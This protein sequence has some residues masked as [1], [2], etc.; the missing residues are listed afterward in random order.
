M[1]ETS[2]TT[3]R[4]AERLLAGESRGVGPAIARGALA[5]IEPAYA[6][7]MT[8]RNAAYDRGWL[9]SHRLPR[10]TISIG[11]ITTGGTG[12]T[13]VVQWLSDQLRR[14]GRRPAILLRGY[15]ASAGRSDEQ[16][17]LE[18]L[19]NQDAPPIPVIANPDRVAGAQQAL[20][21]IPDIDCFLLD[22]AFQHRRVRRDLDIVLINAASPF[23]FGH[24][25]PRGL[26][27]ER[28]AGLKRADVLILT[29]CDRVSVEDLN[30]I[31]QRIRR[32]NPRAPIL[33]ARHQIAGFVDAD[34]RPMDLS[35]CKAFVFTGIGDPDSVVAQVRPMVEVVAHRAFPDHH[36]YTPADLQ[37]IQQ[38]PADVYV[39]TEKDFVKVRPLSPSFPLARIQLEIA[40]APGHAEQL[41]ERVLQAVS[42]ELPGG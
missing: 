18:G 3:T 8:I 19:L 38:T 4:R 20:Q 40:F 41:M 36:D 2:V 35:D 15:K 6:G 7:V 13:P 10:P 34:G 39:T 14:R 21:E 26:L 23:G 22:D 16:T 29:R 9:A 27:R 25:L 24:V 37:A 28:L 17:M 31:T 33:H 5:V 32:H 11:N 1:A 42:R 30:A 12:K